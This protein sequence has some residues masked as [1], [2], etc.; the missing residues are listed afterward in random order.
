MEQVQA[1][2]VSHEGSPGAAGPENR[3]GGRLQA[4]GKPNALVRMNIVMVHQTEARAMEMQAR[5]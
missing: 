3:F 2:C 1:W 4:C 5:P